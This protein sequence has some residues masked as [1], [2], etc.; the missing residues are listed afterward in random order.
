MSPYKNIQQEDWKIV[1]QSLL[2]EHPLDEEEIVE[3][4]LSCWKSIFDSSFGE[5][6]FKVGQDILPKPQIMGFF[7]HELIPLELVGRYQDVWRGDE[8][9]HD[10]DC[11]YKD[12]S[13]YSFEIK[14]SSNPKR[15]FGNR[16]YAQSSSTNKKSKD[17]YYLTVN[18][19]KFT[20]VILNPEILIIRFG[21]IDSTDWIGQ[22]S[23]T[24]QQARLPSE[25]YEGKLKTIYKRIKN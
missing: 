15:I 23:Q 20:K 12:D 18:F 4:V 6:E 3:I 21:W 5:K 10:K 24:G 13:K 17:G 8:D 19:E 1:T 2:D 9:S 14:T 22:K 11:E 7:L 16:S 25:V